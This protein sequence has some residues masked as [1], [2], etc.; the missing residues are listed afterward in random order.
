MT[1]PYI[2][3]EGT[4]YAIDSLSDRARLL[5][6]DLIRTVQEYRALITNY[7]Q[8]VT[9]T[10]TYSGGLKQEVEK[11]EL[12]VAIDNPYTDEEKP[13]IKIG[14][15]SYEATDLPDSV[16][17]YVAELVR[18]N[19]QK[20]Q[21]EFRLRQLDAAR[22]A[23]VKAIQEEIAETKPEPMDPQPEPSDSQPETDGN[24]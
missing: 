5:S 4:S 10:S 9:L 15:V 18:A 21:L 3:V 24:G 12:P 2:T 20:T 1:E 22:G 16:K 6:T 7:R 14:D 13:T 17:A 11:A 23:Y 19:N 8:S